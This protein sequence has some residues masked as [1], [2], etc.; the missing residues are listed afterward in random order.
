MSLR[1]SFRRTC[2]RR[3]RPPSTGAAAER[4]KPAAVAAPVAEP[5]AVV[6]CWPDDHAL[7]QV[8]ADIRAWPTIIHRFG[9]LYG[10]R[11]TLE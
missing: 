7:T 3:T 4:A 8:A 10:R 5:A 9:P 1:H 11:D 6:D 2:L